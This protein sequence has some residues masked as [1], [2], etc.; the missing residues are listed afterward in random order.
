MCQVCTLVLFI[1]TFSVV[2][3]LIQFENYNTQHLKNK[4][5]C[6]NNYY[7]YCAFNPVL[8]ICISRT[9]WK[10]SA[11]IY[12]Y[13]YT[14]SCPVLSSRAGR[15]SQHILLFPLLSKA[16]QWL[17]LYSCNTWC[18]NIIIVWFLFPFRSYKSDDLPC[19]SQPWTCTT[20]SKFNINT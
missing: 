14:L 1:Y 18:V 19:T 3:K 17:A 11:L 15:I 10:V 12:M 6:L 5:V 4:L 7:M 9:H 13:G 20:W 8:C 16:I 2:R